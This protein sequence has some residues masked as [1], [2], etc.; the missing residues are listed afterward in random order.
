MKRLKTYLNNYVT[1]FKLIWNVLSQLY[2]N[3]N[4]AKRIIKFWKLKTGHF[5]PKEDTITVGEIHDGLM[6]HRFGPPNSIQAGE[7]TERGKVIR[8]PIL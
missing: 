7:Y 2:P 1:S 5:L 3:D 4:W 8:P 6:N